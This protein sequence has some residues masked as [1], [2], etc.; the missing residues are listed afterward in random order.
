M[1]FGKYNN[2]KTLYKGTLFDSKK[3]ADYA[4]TLDLLKRASNKKE[5]VLSYEMQVPFQVI[6][7]EKKICKYFADF[8]VH[9]A[10][11]RLEIVDVKGMKTAIYRL[12]KKLVEAQYEV[13][14][15]EV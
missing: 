4:A 12:K 5:C 3:E 11:G 1:R 7:N 10:D 14:I 9:Y 15:K 8:R 6:L 2:K 13:E